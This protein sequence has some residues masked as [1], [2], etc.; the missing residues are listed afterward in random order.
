MT[1]SGVFWHNFK[2]SHIYRAEYGH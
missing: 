1:H 2:E